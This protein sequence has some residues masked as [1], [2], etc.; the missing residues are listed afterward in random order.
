MELESLALFLT[1]SDLGFRPVVWVWCE[2]GP[3]V[4]KLVFDP[5]CLIGAEL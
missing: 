2:V 5:P 4:V 3:R 1:S